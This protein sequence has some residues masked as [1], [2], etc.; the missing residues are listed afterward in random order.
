M[1]GPNPLT[2]HL[3][4][5]RMSSVRLQKF[6][7]DAG[8]ASRRAAERLILAGSVTVNGRIISELGSKVDSDRDEVVVSGSPVKARKKLYIV[9]NKPPGFLCSRTDPEDRRV[10]GDLLP[11]EWT[12]LYTNIY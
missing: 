8:I 6:I 5:K 10:V 9:L 11:A 1:R 3:S 7:S 12:N 2:R 4:L